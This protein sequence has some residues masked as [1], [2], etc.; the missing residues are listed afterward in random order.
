MKNLKEKSI[1]GRQGG[2]TTPPFHPLRTAR[3]MQLSEGEVQ[4]K[5]VVGA[6]R[7][8]LIDGRTD[9]ED[10]E[11]ARSLGTSWCTPVHHRD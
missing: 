8:P 1:D 11:T 10:K 3:L 9:L 7:F 6:G 2:H 5:L 4:A